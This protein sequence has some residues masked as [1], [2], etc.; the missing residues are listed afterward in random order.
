MRYPAKYYDGVT[1]RAQ[2]VT[3]TVTEAAILIFAVDGAVL[4]QWPA[5]RVVLVEL[6]RDGSVRL[7]LTAPRRGHA[8]SHHR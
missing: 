1:A 2:R 8:S 3:V 7:G 4:A 6:A 5:G